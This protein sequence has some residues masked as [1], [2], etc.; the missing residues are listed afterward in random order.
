MR[1]GRAGFRARGVSAET[2]APEA[3]TCSHGMS[4][5]ILSLRHVCASASSGGL[6]TE[7]LVVSWR[8]FIAFSL[9]LVV[10]P[11]AHGQSSGPVLVEVLRQSDVRGAI[12]SAGLSYGGESYTAYSNEQSL[13]LHQRRIPEGALNWNSPSFGTWDAMQRKIVSGDASRKT[14]AVRPMDVPGSGRRFVISHYDPSGTLVA[15]TLLPVTAPPANTLAQM[16]LLAPERMGWLVAV[17][18]DASSAISLHRI[19]WGASQASHSVSLSSSQIGFQLQGA[20]M[21][22]SGQGVIVIGQSNAIVYR[23]N[24]TTGEP[25]VRGTFS[26]PWGTGTPAIADAE[27]TADGQTLFS[28]GM[29]T[30]VIS[31][32][33]T[34]YGS[35]Q[36]LPVHHLT[37]ELPSGWIGDKVSLSRDRR[38]LAMG[39]RIFGTRSIAMAVYDLEGFFAGTGAPVLRVL[40]QVSTSHPTYQLFI[41]RAHI[42]HQ[43]VIF[44]TSGDASDQAGSAPETIVYSLD[45]N[46]LQQASIPVQTLQLPGSIMESYHTLS[47]RRLLVLQKH[48]HANQYVGGADYRVFRVD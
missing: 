26:S 9:L 21:S 19:G 12:D 24:T 7:V 33:S 23:F 10:A 4:H 48:G 1:F 25:I 36:Y 44:T 40:N 43:R 16:F 17:V 27:I 35:P 47:G 41:S 46:S 42:L 13:G 38:Y 31:R 11:V 14:A 32:L 20:K 6:T 5:E 18:R 45:S 30:A 28:V 2:H 34:Q 3:V 8:I 39:A 15:T 37:Q 22:Q 29:G